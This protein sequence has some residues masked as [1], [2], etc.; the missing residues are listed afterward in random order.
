MI[1]TPLCTRLGIEHPIF[2]A[3]MA[4]GAT[5]RN[6]AALDPSKW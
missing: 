3:S 4:G 6:L 5:C 1:R 2:N